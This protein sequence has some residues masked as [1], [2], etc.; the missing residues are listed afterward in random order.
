MNAPLAIQGIFCSPPRNQ[1]LVLILVHLDIGRTSQITYVILAMLLVQHA[2]V[3]SIHNVPH[4]T[5]IIIFSHHPPAQH[6]IALVRTDTGVTM[7]AKNANLVI[8]LARFVLVQA[9][10]DAPLAI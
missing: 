2:R 8:I 10:I 3:L 5:Q 1:R 4:A 7:Q 6:A 9:I